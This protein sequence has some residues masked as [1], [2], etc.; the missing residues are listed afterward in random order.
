MVETKS[1]KSK[2]KKPKQANRSSPVDF[3]GDKVVKVVPFLRRG[4]KN[5][6]DEGEEETS[7]N[8]TIDQQ[9]HAMAST[10]ATFKKAPPPGDRKPPAKKKAPLFKTI[11][12]EE[13]ETPRAA[14]VTPDTPGIVPPLSLDQQQQGQQ[15]GTGMEA[16]SSSRLSDR[17]GLAGGHG[18]SDTVGGQEGDASSRLTSASGSSSGFS[19]VASSTAVESASAFYKSSAGT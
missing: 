1:R 19:D 11:H 18:L 7:N 16:G 8:V 17:A 14:E 12:E 2:K 9:D 6:E 10:G 15:D 3:F 4:G 13:G 5:K